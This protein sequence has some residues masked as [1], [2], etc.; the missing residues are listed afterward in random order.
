MTWRQPPAAP[1]LD[2]VSCPAYPGP[3]LR[4]PACALLGTA[5]PQTAGRKAFLPVPLSEW[6]CLTGLPGDEGSGWGGGVP[7]KDHG[8]GGG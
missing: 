6:P 3:L 2:P 8:E 5:Q 4:P 7:R 1:R